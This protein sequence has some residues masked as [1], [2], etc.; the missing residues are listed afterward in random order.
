MLENSSCGDLVRRRPCPNFQF[1]DKCMVYAFDS[2]NSSH[3]RGHV[4]AGYTRTRQVFCVPGMYLHLGVRVRGVYQRTGMRVPRLYLSTLPRRNDMVH[5]RG[6]PRRP[7]QVSQ[8]QHRNTRGHRLQVNAAVQ[9]AAVE[10]E[11]TDV[12]NVGMRAWEA[13]FGDGFVDTEAEIPDT[14]DI[15]NPRMLYDATAPNQYPVDEINDADGLPTNRAEVC[16]SY[17]RLLE[18]PYGE[19]S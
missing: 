18:F 19:I 11:V 17:S 1:T 9:N 12:E 14:M 7:R 3:I 15:D 16:M 4:H 2:G 13:D 8:A 6:E 10:T 5:G